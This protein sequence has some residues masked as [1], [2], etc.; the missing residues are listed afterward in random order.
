MPGSV[1]SETSVG[2]HEL[3][4]DG[5]ILCR[6]AADVFAELFPTLEVRRDDN[7]RR[8]LL[9]AEASPEARALFAELHAEETLSADELAPRTQLPAATVLAALFELEAS[10]VASEIEAGRYRLAAGGPS[11]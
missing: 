8:R 1:F 2:A 6:G 7:P 11:R 9:P 4:R 5:A 10:G 3:L